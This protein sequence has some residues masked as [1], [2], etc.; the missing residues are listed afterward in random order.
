MNSAYKHT[1]SRKE[2]V[3]VLQT[4]W[5]EGDKPVGPLGIQEA[6]KMNLEASWII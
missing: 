2:C 6:S 4:K 3:V 1:S 5:K